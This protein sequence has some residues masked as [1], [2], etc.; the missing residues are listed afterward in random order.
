MENLFSPCTR[1]HDI[2][3]ESHQGLRSREP[4]QELNLDVSTEVFLSAERGFTYAD[5]YAMLGNESS[6]LWL[7]PHAAVVRAN[8][9]WMSLGRIMD[10]L[11]TFGLKADGKEMIVLARSPEHRLEICDV[12][13]R[14]LA[15]SVVRSVVLAASRHDL[16]INA[17]SLA[18]MMEHCQSLKTLSL[19]RLT[20]D[21]NHCRVLDDYSRPGLEIEI[22]LASCTITDAGARA[23]AGILGRNQGLTRLDD[24]RIKLSILA[25]GLR[26]NSR[27]KNLSRGSRFIS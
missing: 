7:N 3:L 10:D 24:C 16:S 8:E 17:P 25:D 20:L 11:F 18:H 2:L 22:E 23:L 27:L 15:A 4:L 6:V 9:R 12:V 5:L 26:G 1:F 21:E 19:K 13:L 14:L